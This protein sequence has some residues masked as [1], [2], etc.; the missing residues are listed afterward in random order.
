MQM[1]HQEFLHNQVLAAFHRQLNEYYPLPQQ[2]L[3][4]YLAY[5]RERSQLS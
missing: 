2:L 3:M 4:E 5:G 1:A